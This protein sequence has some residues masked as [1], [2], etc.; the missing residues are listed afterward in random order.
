MNVSQDD[1]HTAPNK[2]IKES[3]Q[4]NVS[5]GQTPSETSNCP[6]WCLFLLSVYII[7]FVCEEF[8]VSIP[9]STSY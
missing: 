6:L 3:L 5:Q 4:G 9:E 8:N 1:F 7:L 2:I